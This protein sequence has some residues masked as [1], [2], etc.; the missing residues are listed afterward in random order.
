MSNPKK[1][2]KVEVCINCDSKQSVHDSVSAALIG[3]AST[4]ELC[5][6]MKHEGLTPTRAHITEAR[7]SFQDKDGLMVMIR[8]RS[9]DFH[10]SKEEIEFM[11]Q[12]IKTAGEEQANGVVFGVLEEKDN[13]LAVGALTMLMETSREY[14]LKVTFH[15]AFDATPNPL[16]TLE[17]LIDAGIDR[18]LTSGTV[19]GDKKKAIDGIDRLR[20]IIARAQDRIEIVIGGGIN[21]RNVD[22]ILTQLPSLYNNISVH[23]YSGVQENGITTVKAVNSLV[24]VVKDKES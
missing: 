24:G 23:T 9:G 4:V 5:A 22:K 1:M 19:W 7:D 13:S 10:Y 18:I 8:P 6:A 11:Q 20:Q 16:E 21:S 2:I 15:R 12:Q 17:L 14:N 3:G